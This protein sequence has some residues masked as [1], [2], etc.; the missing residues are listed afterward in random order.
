M[1]M[2]AE[3]KKALKKQYNLV[4]I[5]NYCRANEEA[6][7]W[8]NEA[9]FRKVVKPVFPKGAD[10]KPDKSQAP[11]MVEQDISFIELQAE[12]LAKFI[13]GYAEKEEKQGKSA[14]RIKL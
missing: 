6:R 10:G 11:A 14:M 9:A 7:A 5:Q 2:S 1:A 8:Y 4:G 3:Q 12:F 13:E